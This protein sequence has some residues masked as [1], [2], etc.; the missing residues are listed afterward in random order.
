M[1]I[2]SEAPWRGESSERA[3]CFDQPPYK[4]G[5]GRERAAPC[6]LSSPVE[7]TSTGCR[8][9]WS[10]GLHLQNAVDKSKL[11]FISTS[12]CMS[13]NVINS[14]NSV[15]IPAFVLFFLLTNATLKL[16]YLQIIGFFFKWKILQPKVLFFKQCFYIKGLF[17]LMDSSSY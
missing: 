2:R 13:L 8:N 5:S 15:D 3:P 12:S 10:N 6:W 4:K 16:W 1:C 14:G 7:N 9:F 11:R 17:P